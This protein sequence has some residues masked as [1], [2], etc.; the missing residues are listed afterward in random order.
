LHTA[1]Y[2]ASAEGGIQ[3]TDPMLN[4]PWPLP[5]ADLSIRDRSHPLLSSAF[6]GLLV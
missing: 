1:S 2:E 3:P 5:I 4:I 6:P